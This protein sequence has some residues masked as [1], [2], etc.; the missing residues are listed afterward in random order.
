MKG[1]LLN[2]ESVQQW[3][4]LGTNA[5]QQKGIRNECTLLISD[6]IKTK[7]EKKKIKL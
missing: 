2:F 3:Q 1:T 4:S 6:S 5:S 7:N